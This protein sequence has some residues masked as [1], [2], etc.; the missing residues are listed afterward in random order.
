[1]ENYQILILKELVDGK[2]KDGNKGGHTGRQLE[3]EE[4][5]L[6]GRLILWLSFE[7]LALSNRRALQG[8]SVHHAGKCITHPHTRHLGPGPM[9]ARLHP[10]CQTY[11]VRFGPHLHI[12]CMD[13]SSF[14]SYLQQTYCINMCACCEGNADHHTFPYPLH[15][16]QQ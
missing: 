15:T 5:V 8:S 14:Y 3:E 13:K 6:F 9:G 4:G 16:A 2:E 12:S 1:M 11:P 10:A 7:C